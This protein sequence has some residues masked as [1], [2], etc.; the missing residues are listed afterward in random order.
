[1]ANKTKKNIPSSEINSQSIDYLGLKKQPFNNEI[2]TGKSYFS[3]PALTKITDS[4]IHQ[5]Q[6]SDLILLVEG[7]HGTGKTSFFRQFIQTN[8]ANTKILSIQAES[9]DTLLQIQQKISIHLQDLGDAEQLDNNLKSLKMF[10]QTPLIVINNSHVLSDTTLQELF[11]YQ[12]QLTRELEVNLKFLLFANTGMAD[13]LQK[14]TDIQ[15]EQMYLQTLPEL[16]PK[17]A[18]SFIMHR[19]RSAG[20]SGEPLFDN[21]TIQQLFKKGNVTPLEIM[22]QAA[23]LVDKMIASKL[24]PASGLWLKALI[25][26]IILCI[27][28]AGSY[29]AYALL[30]TNDNPATTDIENKINSTAQVTTDKPEVEKTAL[31]QKNAIETLKNDTA[32]AEV[33]SADVIPQTDKHLNL[34]NNISASHSDEKVNA[35]EKQK[36]VLEKPIDKAE[37]KPVVE[38]TKTTAKPVTLTNP[39]LLQLNKMGLHNIDWLVSQSKHN[40]TLQLLGARE[41][42]TLLKFAQHYKLSTSTAWYKTWL[43]AKPYYVLVHGSYTSR[44]EA[45]NA[46]AQLPAQLRANK[47]W[48]KSMQSV[49]K[50]ISSNH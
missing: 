8:I 1:M 35:P 45:R 13:T 50:S 7:K 12:Q 32:Q 4:L 15:A 44:N 27:V 38:K 34:D 49:Q 6:F 25:A 14:I 43:S 21:K 20:Y 5:V 48:V 36:T 3:Y 24:K 26:F 47:P 9:T 28:V 17:Q 30:L 22:I 31:E 2:L 46:I 41:P 37:A 11:R 40:W 23:P 42:E 19:L 39:A 16:P 29:I 33:R 10:D 18:D